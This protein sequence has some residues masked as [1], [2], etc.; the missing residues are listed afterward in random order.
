M[1][2]FTLVKTC[3]CA[4]TNPRT[5]SALVIAAMVRFSCTAALNSSSSLQSPESL[6]RFSSLLLGRPPLLSLLLYPWSA[7]RGCEA[8]PLRSFLLWGEPLQQRSQGSLSALSRPAAVFPTL[9]PLSLFGLSCTGRSSCPWPLGPGCDTELEVGELSGHRSDSSSRH[10][11]PGANAHVCPC[12]LLLGLLSLSLD[13][14]AGLTSS[15]ELAKEGSECT[16]GMAEELLDVAGKL[17]PGEPA[18]LLLG[19]GS[20]ALPTRLPIAPD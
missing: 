12:P 17:T 5:S 8:S 15:L 18:H 4:S 16:K 7:L 9:L 2:A 20:K 3:P 13:D 14:R 19:D 10:R 6:L 1:A 11:G